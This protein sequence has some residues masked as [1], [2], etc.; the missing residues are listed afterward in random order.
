VD[1]SG[2]QTR[3]GEIAAAVFQAAVSYP[4]CGR[5]AVISENPAAELAQYCLHALTAAGL[6]SKA[7]VAR[8]LPNM[9]TDADTHTYRGQACVT[10]EAATD[11]LS[12]WNDQL[13]AMLLEPTDRDER[14]GWRL[15]RDHGRENACQH[16]KRRPVA[17]WTW[18][19]ASR[20][21]AMIREGVKDGQSLSSGA[22]QEQG[23]GCGVG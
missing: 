8:L 7:A 3:V 5:R 19:A 20:P 18:R 9:V 10:P 1:R 12:V 14:V 17:P 21:R 13:T 15:A 4:R 23:S 6:T 22:R 16:D 11:A 2:V